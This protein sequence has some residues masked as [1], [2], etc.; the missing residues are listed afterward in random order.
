[1]AVLVIVPLIATVAKSDDWIFFL[2]VL[3]TDFA[4]MSAVS[5]IY[6]SVL[7]RRLWEQVSGSAS[8]SNSSKEKVSTFRTSMSGEGTIS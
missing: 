7:L 8:G 1:M 5:S 3:G 2:A 4:I 6:G